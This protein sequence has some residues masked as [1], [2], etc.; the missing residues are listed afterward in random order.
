MALLNILQKRF[1]MKLERQHGK[2]LLLNLHRRCPKWKGRWWRRRLTGSTTMGHISSEE[3]HDQRR[4]LGNHHAEL[5]PCLLALRD[6][7]LHHA[8]GV[9]ILSSGTVTAFRSALL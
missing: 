4:G 8:R 2:G 5:L 3:K 9:L 6:G 1:V 7:D